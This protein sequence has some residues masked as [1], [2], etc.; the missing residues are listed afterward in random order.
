MF[1]ILNCDL[2][3]QA[4]MTLIRRLQLKTKM[5]KQVSRPLDKLQMYCVKEDDYFTNVAIIIICHHPVK[6]EIP[7]THFA[8]S[9]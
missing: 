1:L 3:H 6:N 7:T 4:S 9:I 2:Y 5:A 8:T